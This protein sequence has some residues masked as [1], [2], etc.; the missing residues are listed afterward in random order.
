MEETNDNTQEMIAPECVE[1]QRN[2]TI[3]GAQSFLTALVFVVI[4]RVFS[5]TLSVLKIE[6]GLTIHLYEILV[7]LLE[8]IA[9]KY[10]AD[11]ETYIHSMKNGKRPKMHLKRALVLKKVEIGILCLFTIITVRYSI[12]AGWLIFGDVLGIISNVVGSICTFMAILG[13]KTLADVKDIK[14]GSRFTNLL[15]LYT[16]K[17]LVGIVGSVFGFKNSLQGYELASRLKTQSLVAILLA[18]TVVWFVFLFI[19]LSSLIKTY[20]T[21]AEAVPE[22][23]KVLRKPLLMGLGSLFIFSGIL[24]GLKLSM[25]VQTKKEAVR[26]FENNDRQSRTEY[27]FMATD[28][29]DYIF[30]TTFE[31]IIPINNVVLMVHADHIEETGIRYNNISGLVFGGTKNN[32]FVY[33]DYFFNPRLGYAEEAYLVTLEDGIKIVVMMP[34]FVYE[35]VLSGSEDGI[36]QLPMGNLH[37]VN[38]RTITDNAKWKKLYNRGALRDVFVDCYSGIKDSGVTDMIYENEERFPFYAKSIMAII[39]AIWVYIVFGKYGNKQKKI[40]PDR[41]QKAVKQNNAN[42]H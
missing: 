32:Y 36:V 12:K 42:M 34:A 3:R 22:V 10:L 17:L 1:K 25:I 15:W 2:Y 21:D 13:L 28:S 7:A 29:D 39:V 27:G 41:L 5:V 24:F 23:K 35:K 33:D 11:G 31:E 19:L 20:S 6:G 30:A 4:G 38:I 9:Y 8:C 40:T 14:L 18:L 37:A 26:I 16:V